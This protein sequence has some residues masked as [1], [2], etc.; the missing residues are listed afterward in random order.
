MCLSKCAV[1]AEE[2]SSSLSNRTVED[3][4]IP[5]RRS[6][7]AVELATIAILV[8]VDLATISINLSISETG[9]KAL[10]DRST[11]GAEPRPELTAD[12]WK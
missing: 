4:T 11:K 5:L 1:M 6:R 12:G 3:C 7:L 10:E 8:S 9:G 2:D